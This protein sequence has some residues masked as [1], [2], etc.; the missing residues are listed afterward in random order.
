MFSESFEEKHNDKMR[1]LE[2]KPIDDKNDKYTQR[3]E[4]ELKQ[5]F[6]V[7]NTINWW[8]SFLGEDPNN[9]NWEKN[10][11]P[12]GNR[13]SQ[14]PQIFESEIWQITEKKIPWFERVLPDG[15]K[16]RVVCSDD[17]FLLNI[18]KETVSWKKEY[19]TIKLSNFKNMENDEQGN[20]KDKKQIISMPKMTVTWNINL[21]DRNLDAWLREN[22]TWDLI[23]FNIWD[24]YDIVKI[25][26]SIEENVMRLER[27]E[28]HSHEHKRQQKNQEDIENK[29]KE[30]S[31]LLMELSEEMNSNPPETYERIIKYVMDS[32]SENFDSEWQYLSAR[33]AFCAL[34]ILLQSVKNIEEVKKII[35][36]NKEINIQEAAN[37]KQIEWWENLVEYMKNSP[38]LQFLID[39]ESKI[40]SYVLQ[41]NIITEE[42]RIFL[43]KVYKE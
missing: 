12:I 22:V 34:C 18:T 13:I 3:E 37:R 10:R 23:D 33:Q 35:L 21:L 20:W 31:L 1:E 30:Y 41:S 7:K 8:V 4:K 40:I 29:Q 6:D 17:S 2:T 39:N 42:E 43:S 25:V 14:V 26:N 16:A 9:L 28:V 27:E 32:N 24:Q 5:I 36:G 11:Y 38:D 15:S 19:L